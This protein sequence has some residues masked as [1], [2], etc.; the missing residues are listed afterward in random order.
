MKLPYFKLKDAFNEARESFSYGSG[1]DKITS[2]AK[3]LGKSIANVG[4]GAVEIGAEAIKNAPEI[5]GK[6]AK[7]H[8]DK[9]SNS[10]T[11]DQIER[12]KNIVTKGEEARK[13][14]LEK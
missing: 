4:M 2:A 13:R 14:R 5:A 9:N 12:A 3:L 7:N 11:E 10:M 1:S 8:L 6:A